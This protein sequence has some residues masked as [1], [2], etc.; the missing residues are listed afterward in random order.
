[1]ST[2]IELL[3]N[4]TRDYESPTAFWKWSGYVS[5]AAILRN[6][7]WLQDGDSKLYPNIYVLFLASSG[8]R[9]G[10]PV[11]LS[12]RMVKE[13]HV[14]KTLSGR[15]SIQGI[16]DELAHTETDSKTGQM[17]KGGSAI[18]YAEELAAGIVQSEEAISILTDIYDGKTDFK[19]ILR[20]SPRFKVEQIVF[21]T[22][23]ASNEEMLKNFYNHQATHGGLLARTFLI[24]PA[25]EFR[26]SNS[27]LKK[28][29]KSIGYKRCVDSLS[30][31]SKLNGEIEFDETARNEYDPW[32]TK[33]R[34]SYRSGDKGGIA[35]RMHTG[36]KKLAIILAAN[37]ESLI[38]RKRHIEE[39]IIE[40]ITLIP[41]YNEFI[42][43]SGKS[44]IADAG[45]ILL[46]EL[47]N[48]D[49]HC[50][51]RR[52]VLRNH[53]QDIDAEIL[54]KLAITLEQ[55]GM[56]QSILSSTENTIYYRLTSKALEILGK[57]KT[58][59]AKANDPE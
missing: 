39:A 30:E 34:N 2:F 35:G 27:L 1:M 11:Q 29:D 38:V 3:L 23:L 5:I 47:Q 21:N 42:M 20:H 15:S 25:G 50:L 31:I 36:V 41:N 16:I 56:I 12:E 55:A 14:T 10:R 46:T 18:W 45:A 43:A 49:D 19:S 52:I 53:W 17:L 26:E 44:T 22:L 24:T 51:D 13:L 4:H 32:Y 57:G 6:N 9:K 40:C 48:K 59:E 7:V 58:K 37:E 28:V 8:A 33:F 54:D